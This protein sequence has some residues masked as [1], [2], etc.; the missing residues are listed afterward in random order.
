MEEE[1]EMV[2]FQIISAVGAAKG[3]YIDAIH[4]AKQGNINAARAKVEEGNKIFVEG[5]KAH[6][7]LIQKSAAGEAVSINMLLMHAEDQLMSAE[8]V[9]ILANELIDAY[10][11]MQSKP[12]I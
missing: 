3:M 12:E 9:K 6:A 5:H 4:E 2:S 10:E 11:Q 7:N 1:L 8:T